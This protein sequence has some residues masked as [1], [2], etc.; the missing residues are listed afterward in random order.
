MPESR[1]DQAGR[2][3]SCPN[4]EPTRMVVV[5]GSGGQTVW[6]VIAVCLAVIATALVGRLDN[7]WLARSA[8]AQNVGNPGMPVT[9][10]RGIY[11][12]AGQLGA[13]EYGLYMMDVDTGTV[14]CYEMARGRDNSLQMQLVAARSW[15]FDRF[16]E[17]YNVAKPT[18]NEVQFMVRQQRENPGAAP[19]A[20]PG[21][22]AVPTG[23]NASQPS[24]EVPPISPAL[25]QE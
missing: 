24:A 22:P 2:Q 16:L 11:A 20:W 5:S 23:E 4:S 14:W 12:F 6:W 25:P 21:A 7:D 19:G 13:K 18:P 17:E 1:L 10:T 9:G 3:P 8:V 15:I